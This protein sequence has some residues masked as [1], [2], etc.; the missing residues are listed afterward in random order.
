MNTPSSKPAKNLNTITYEYYDN[1]PRYMNSFNSLC[2]L[3]MGLFIYIVTRNINS[4]SNGDQNAATNL[5]FIIG[6]CLLSIIL[7]Y[8][9]AIWAL[10]YFI[11]AFKN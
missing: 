9:L 1:T 6:I 10:A 2:C 11:N 8:I 3:M 5:F 4:I 7:V